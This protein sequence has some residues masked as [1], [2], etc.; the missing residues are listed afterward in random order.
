MGGKIEKAAAPSIQEAIDIE[1]Q[2]AHEW[3]HG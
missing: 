3:L 1:V 2:T